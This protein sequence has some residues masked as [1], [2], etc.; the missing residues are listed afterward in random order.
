MAKWTDDQIGLLKTLKA[1]G[2]SAGVIITFDE[3]RGKTRNA[4]L[5]KLH[6]LGLLQVKGPRPQKH[7]RNY[8]KEQQWVERR[9]AAPRISLKNLKQP[10]V[11]IDIDCN[12][13]QSRELSLM[14]LTPET[15]KWPSAHRPYTFCGNQRYDLSRAYCQYHEMRSRQSCGEF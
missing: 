10:R 8:Q 2:Y 11:I 1:D 9:L 15:C 7:T 12:A 14:E 6:R 3:F 13:P 5:G 4:I